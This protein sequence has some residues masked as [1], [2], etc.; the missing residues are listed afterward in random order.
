M[1]GGAPGGR[2]ADHKKLL[3]WEL[4]LEKKS[5][6]SVFFLDSASFLKKIVRC[7]NIYTKI[8]IAWTKNILHQSFIPLPTS[9]PLKNFN[10]GVRDV[11][12]SSGKT[13]FASL[14]EHSDRGGLWC[15]L[16]TSRLT[17]AATGIL[18]AHN[19]E[20]E[21]EAKMTGRS[22]PSTSEPKYR[23]KWLGGAP[24]VPPSQNSWKTAQKPPIW[25][26]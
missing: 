22:P 3:Q 8:F 24:P 14:R 16:T 1:W 6:P 18:N 19:L 9:L 15:S 20:M 26:L 13:R 23:P 5:R 2:S 25:A 7:K 10:T 12:A 4:C 11:I 17:L 21:K